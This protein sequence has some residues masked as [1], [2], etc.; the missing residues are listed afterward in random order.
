MGARQ[1]AEGTIG[2]VSVVEVNADGGDILGNSDWWTDAVDAFF[3]GPAV[4]ACGLLF[5][6]D[7]DGHILMPTH[8]PVGFRGFVKVYGFDQE[9]VG[10]DLLEDMTEVRGEE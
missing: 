3:E 1:Y 6:C 7:I 8:K 2:C 5:G 9:S 4:V 10:V